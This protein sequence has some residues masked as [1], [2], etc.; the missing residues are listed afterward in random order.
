MIDYKAMKI[1]C[2]GEG[3]FE[4]MRSTECPNIENRKETEK[5]P[6]GEGDIRRK[7]EY[8]KTS[9]HKSR[10]K[11]RRLTSM[12]FNKNSTFITLTFA[13]NIQDHAIANHEFKKFIQRLNRKCVKEKFDLKYIA[14]IEYQKR[15]AIHYHMICNYSLKFIKGATNRMK[16][17][18][19]AKKT[20][21]NGFC[22]IKDICGKDVDNV[23]AY[24]V[25]YMTKSDTIQEQKQKYL[26]SRNLLEP[27]ILDQEETIY[28]KEELKNH[29]PKMSATLETEYWGQ[30]QYLQ[31]N[32]AWEK[33]GL[34]EL[35]KL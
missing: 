26:H 11:F 32:F 18:N 21:K 13:E 6:N 30:I 12:N 33:K 3:I 17:D 35:N 5:T 19:F 14:T 16:E 7:E 9:I 15:G 27:I 34:E 31:Y 23:G 8:L 22:N 28:W 4:V 29:Y 1:T 20:W 10:E 24:L 25:K 2:I